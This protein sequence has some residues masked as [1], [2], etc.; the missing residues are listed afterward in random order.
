MKKGLKLLAL[1]ALPAVL[2]ACTPVAAWERGTLA[3]PEMA[4]DA[5]PLDSA[6]DNHVYFSKEASSGGNSASGGGCGCN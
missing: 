1:L 2:S 6:L 3:K 4:L 5:D